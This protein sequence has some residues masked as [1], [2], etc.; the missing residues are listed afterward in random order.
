MADKT[1]AVTPE[2]WNA[3]YPVGTPVVAYPGVRPEHPTGRDCPRLETRTRTEA[4][5]LGGHTSV[6]MVED[7]VS[8]ISLDHVDPIESATDR[9]TPGYVETPEQ[10]ATRTQDTGKEA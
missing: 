3:R 7:H 6:V 9:E 2:Q 4:W 8:C 10:W 5:L 1:K